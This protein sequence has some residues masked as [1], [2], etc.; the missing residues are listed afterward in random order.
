MAQI[1]IDV[2]DAHVNRVLDAFANE[3]GW[4]AG[5]GVTKAQFA[6]SKVASWI[7]L[8]VKQNE[9]KLAQLSAATAITD[10]TVS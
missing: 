4:N 5:L 9:I 7:K 10:T 2:D 6:K 3:F 1:I 8:I